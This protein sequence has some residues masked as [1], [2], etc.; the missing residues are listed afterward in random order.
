MV[1]SNISE[2]LMGQNIKEKEISENLVM[3]DMIHLYFKIFIR[4]CI[5]I[6]TLLIILQ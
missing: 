6:N 1:V 5:K 3:S 2:I 4:A